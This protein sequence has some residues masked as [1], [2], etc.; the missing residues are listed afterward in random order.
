MHMEG[1]R[2]GEVQSNDEDW[3]EIES[4]NRMNRKGVTGIERGWCACRNNIYAKLNI[5]RT[6]LLFAIPS[7]DAYG[8][9]GY[10]SLSSRIPSCSPATST[11]ASSHSSRDP[12]SNRAIPFPRMLTCRQ[13]MSSSMYRSHFSLESLRNRSDPALLPR[14][15]AELLKM[16]L[17]F[18]AARRLSWRLLHSR[19]ISAEK[20]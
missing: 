6:V 7:N 10:S 18:L 11:E 8:S 5:H 19:L 9:H 3:N 15:L 2:V 20:T 17:H 1:L 13:Q 4:L 12:R 16:S 14:L